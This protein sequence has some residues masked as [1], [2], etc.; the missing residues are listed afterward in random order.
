MKGAWNLATLVVTCTALLTLL[1][2]EWLIAL[3]VAFQVSPVVR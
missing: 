2:I 1:A 3:R